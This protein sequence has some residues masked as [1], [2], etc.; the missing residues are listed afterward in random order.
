MRGR[1]EVFGSAKEIYQPQA[2]ASFA[3]ERFLV[4]GFFSLETALLCFFLRWYISRTNATRSYC[5][6][7]TGE[8]EPGARECDWGRVAEQQRKDKSHS[9]MQEESLTLPS[10][11]FASPRLSSMSI[12]H[13]ANQI[14]LLFSQASPNTPQIY[15][16]L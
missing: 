16:K 11:T 5:M 6:N 3:L 1:R 12:R 15:L 10:R 9:W 4:G 7:P 8:E 2:S 13:N 14:I